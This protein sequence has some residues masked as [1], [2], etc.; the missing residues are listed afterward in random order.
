MP[1]LRSAE[2]NG[3]CGGASCWR[4]QRQRRTGVRNQA[5]LSRERAEDLARIFHS[6]FHR[7]GRRRRADAAHGYPSDP[8]LAE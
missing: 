1:L 3:G 6:N 5:L 2:M 7:P 8:G 4:Q